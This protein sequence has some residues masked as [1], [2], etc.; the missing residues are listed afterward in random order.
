MSG[1]VVSVR[2]YV[3]IFLALLCF[4]GLT[5]GVA[6]IDMGYMNTVA[7][8]LIALIKMLLVV[9]FFMHVR[10]SSNLIK[11]VVASGFFWLALLLFFTMSDYKTRYWTAPPS[12]WGPSMSSSSTKP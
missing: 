12:D 3:T 9:L 1:H 10:Y 8:L 7:A 2:L 11:L 4:T 5:V 6:Y